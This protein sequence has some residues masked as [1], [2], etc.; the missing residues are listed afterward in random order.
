M[1]LADVPADPDGAPVRAVRDA[2]QRR[3]HELVPG[4][5][6]TYARGSDQYP[7]G[8]A[9]VL[10]RGRGRPGRG[11]GRQHATSSTAWACA[12]SPSATATS[13]S[14]RPCAAIA[15]GLASRRPSEPGAARRRDVPRPGA[16]R[17]HGEVRQE[18]VGR[19]HC[20]G[21]AG[22]GGHRAPAGRDLPHPAVLLHR[23]LVHRHHADARGHPWTRSAG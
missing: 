7:E 22:P 16:G 8:M 12:R 14:S 2:A 18:R 17:R 20:G 6:H 11:R 21:Q 4:G 1:T 13:R 9:P 15:D 23:R 3:L 10:V 19:H 5:A